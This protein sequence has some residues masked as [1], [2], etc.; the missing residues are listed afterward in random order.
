VVHLNVTAKP[1][2]NKG[3][4]KNQLRGR[5]NIMKRI[6]LACTL[7]MA[8]L[9]CSNHFVNIAEAQIARG[10]NINKVM[11]GTEYVRPKGAMGARSSVH[12]ITS[13][14]AWSD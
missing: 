9:V 6:T 12:R 14:T 3:F 11:L 2:E 8:A 5:I 4:D 1:P 10:I 13:S 7:G